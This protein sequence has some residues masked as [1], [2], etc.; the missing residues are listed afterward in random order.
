MKLRKAL[1]ITNSHRVGT[2][3]PQKISCIEIEKFDRYIHMSQSHVW[4]HYEKVDYLGQ[5]LIHREQIEGCC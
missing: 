2:L 1:R 5:D 4:Q 3:S